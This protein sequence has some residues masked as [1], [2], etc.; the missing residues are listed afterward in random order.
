MRGSFVLF[1]FLGLSVG[2]CP[3]ELQ[4]KI[5]N[6]IL[7]ANY[8]GIDWGIQILF[9]NDQNGFDVAYERNAY[10]FFIPASN[11]KLL[12]TSALLTT[13]GP[14][15]TFET[16][17]SVDKKGNVCVKG[18]GDPEMTYDSIQYI[19][20]QIAKLTQSVPNLYIDDTLFQGDPFP[21]SWEW[22]DLVEYYGAQPTTFV[23]EQNAITLSITPATVVGQSPTISF[24]Q[25]SDEDI[26]SFP[27]QNGIVTDNSP[28]AN[29]D[30]YWILGRNKLFLDGTIGINAGVQQITASV[31]DPTQHFA[32]LLSKKLDK[33]IPVTTVSIE[34]CQHSGTVYSL[35]SDPI[36]VLMT[37]CLK[38]SDNLYAELFAKILGALDNPNQPATQYGVE[39][40]SQILVNEFGLNETLFRQIDGCGLS[41]ENL[42][43]PSTFASLLGSM[44]QSQYGDLFRSFL[45]IAGVDG[46]LADRF[47]GTPAQGIVQAKTGT[48]HGVDAL[49]GYMSHPEFAPLVV[50]SVIANN[51]DEYADIVR[52]AIDAIVLLLPAL[53]QC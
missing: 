5:E 46:T 6:I 31:I 28:W 42:I 1:V 8:S 40:V 11:T 53:R 25:G 3:S 33:L 2:L 50:F 14:N 17:W 45:P 38:E 15:L 43:T 16:T 44:Y 9:S 21:A 49:S 52:P 24:M 32:Q 37:H 12:T 19:A 30:Y 36:S 23:V 29:I 13:R 35:P 4:G 27:Y 48:E 7:S 26:I 34:P 47:V 20:Q 18:G 10:D 22:G 39:L 51:A 41:P